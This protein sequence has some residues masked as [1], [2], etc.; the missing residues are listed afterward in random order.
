VPSSAWRWFLFQ[1]RV[2]ILYSTIVHKSYFC[3]ILRNAILYVIIIIIIILQ[4]KYQYEL[5]KIVRQG[6]PIY[7]VHVK[8]MAVPASEE[9]NG[10]WE[11]T[12]R[13]SKR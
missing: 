3:K 13:S 6:A 11:G 5:N 8:W 4:N 7:L 10:P 1:R 12:A 9:I 2:K